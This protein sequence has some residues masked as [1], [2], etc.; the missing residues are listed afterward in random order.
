MLTTTIAIA[1]ILGRLPMLIADKF[2][3]M[4]MYVQRLLIVFF[5]QYYKLFVAF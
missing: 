3:N 4:L 2:A 1:I 5:F